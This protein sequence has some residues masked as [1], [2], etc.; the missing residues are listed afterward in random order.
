[1]P[2]PRTAGESR[3]SRT[4][5]H[6]GEAHKSRSTRRWSAPSSEMDSRA[7]GL[8]RDQHWPCNKPKRASSAPTPSSNQAGRRDAVW[9]CSA[10]RSADASIAKRLRCSAGLLA[11]APGIGSRGRGPQ[12]SPRSQAAGP[13]S[14]RFRP[15]AHTCW[16]C[17]FG[18]RRQRRCRAE[19]V[20]ARWFMLLRS[21]SV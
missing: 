19:L 4:A 2:P 7:Q 8:M 6:F 13:H 12:Q 10:W 14:Q 9:W 18:L 11:L 20:L 3:S 1:M 5:S 16:S 15:C 21:F 17:R